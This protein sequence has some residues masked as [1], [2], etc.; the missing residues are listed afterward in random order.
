[1][2]YSQAEARTLREQLAAVREELSGEKQRSELLH[3]TV[4]HSTGT[5]TETEGERVCYRDIHVHCIL[6]CCI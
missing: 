2:F 5:E 6:Q 1:M 3:R 4:T